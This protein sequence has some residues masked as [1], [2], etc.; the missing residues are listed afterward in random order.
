MPDVREVE[1]ALETLH[2]FSVFSEK[3]GQEMQ[4]LVIE[5]QILLHLDKID[6]LKRWSILNFFRKES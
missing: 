2:N 3:R 6:K 4:D 5:F 1:G